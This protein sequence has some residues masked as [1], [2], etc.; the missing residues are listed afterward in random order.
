[1]YAF[2]KKGY[3]FR[4]WAA[5]AKVA[6]RLRETRDPSSPVV[7][8]LRE[9]TLAPRPPH[10]M[11]SRRTDRL[12]KPVRRVRPRP[13]PPHVMVSRRT[14]RLRKPVRHVRPRPRPRHAMVSRRTDRLRKPVRNVR[15]RLR[16]V[17]V[18]SCC[19]TARTRI[20]REYV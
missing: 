8:P 4:G 12:R 16:G 17:R 15:P 2:A 10:A 5:C 14:D 11:V 9:C 18:P 19:G 20:A 7:T 6:F 13:R 3:R 1:M